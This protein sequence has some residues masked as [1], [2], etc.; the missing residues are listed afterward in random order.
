MKKSD[1]QRERKMKF[2]QIEKLI[3][4][5]DESSINEFRY[6][7]EE[8]NLRICKNS[9]VQYVTAESVSAQAQP[10]SASKS[11]EVAIVKEAQPV[12]EPSV[13][14]SADDLYEITSPMVGTF[15][16]SSNPDAP[17][18]VEVGS[19]VK[20]NTVVCMLEAMK[21]FNQIEAEVSGEI[22]EICVEN[23]QF[24]EYGQPLFRVKL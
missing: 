21:L 7:T 12:A 13:D 10:G 3:K 1:R 15:Y 24:V 5:L 20:K 9:S 8:V 6:E 22:A 18:F 11:A 19:K 4:L 16:A 17:P 2:D 14:N 23:G